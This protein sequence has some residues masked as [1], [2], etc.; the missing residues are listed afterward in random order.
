MNTIEMNN[1]KDG[2]LYYESVKSEIMNYASWNQLRALELIDDGIES[3]VLKCF[4]EDYGYAILKK[5]KN[6]SIIED[7]YNTLVEYNGRCF[8]KIFDGD[9]KNGIILEEQVLPGTELR[10]VESLDKRLSIFCSLHKELHIK[11]SV[12]VKYP[13]YM[14]WV[15][16]I[17]RY[18]E[19]RED[20]KEL[21]C[22]M[23]KAESIC[24]ELFLMYPSRMLLHG[25]LHHDNILLNNRKEYTIIDPKGVIGDPIFDIPRFILNE[26]EDNID[27]ELYEKIEYITSVIGMQLNIPIRV[28]KQVFYIEMTMAECWNAEDGMTPN[29]H[30]VI[31]AERVLTTAE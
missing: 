12:D 16:K 22:Y 13:T 17:T 7:E 15:N 6:V 28:V 29:L 14:D 31:F 4:S 23:K 10:K 5:R 3:C 25:D 21:Y 11:P 20:Y 19:T 1:I 24:K 18:M 9:I 30:N 27:H 2:Q 26:M 8:C